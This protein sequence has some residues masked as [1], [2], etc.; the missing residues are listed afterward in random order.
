MAFKTNTYRCSGTELLAFQ[1]N[2]YSWTWM[3]YV[4]KPYTLVAGRHLWHL[5][6]APLERGGICGIR[7]KN[8]YSCVGI[9]LATFVPNTHGAGQGRGI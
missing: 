8:I 4:K 7:E 5:L 1:I 6:L 9:S 3:A 2:I